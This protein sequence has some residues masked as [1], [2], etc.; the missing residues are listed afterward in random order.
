MSLLW[1]KPWTG[2]YV[3]TWINIAPK[4]GAIQLEVSINCYLALLR[5]LGNRKYNEKSTVD[6]NEHF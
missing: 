1:F 2:E 5:M 6:Y 3:L 4:R